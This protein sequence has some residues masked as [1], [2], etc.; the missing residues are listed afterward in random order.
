VKAQLTV[1][2]QLPREATPDHLDILIL[3]AAEARTAGVAPAIDTLMA[4]QSAM[5]AAAPRAEVQPRLFLWQQPLA[6]VAVALLVVGIGVSTVSIVRGPGQEQVAEA[7]AVED[8][9]AEAARPE[10]PEEAV[11]GTEPE[12]VELAEVSKDEVA[13]RESE[14]KPP[15]ARQAQ[16]AR[17][18]SQKK[19]ERR[20]AGRDAPAPAAPEQEPQRVAAAETDQAADT[21]AEQ[22]D[23]AK[24]PAMKTGDSKDALSF[25]KANGQQGATSEAE[26]Q[27]ISTILMFEKRLKDKVN[28]KPTPQ[29]AL[30]AGLCYQRL[31]KRNQAQHWLKRAAEYPSTSARAKEALDQLK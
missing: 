21:S 20:A 10:D 4:E 5:D 9:T 18:R 3:Q 2:S 28:Y 16:A 30:D 31:G 25:G 17:A 12:R 11:G 19:K 27:C 24:L 8:Q 6:M 1:A 13:A 7:P 22:Y 29:Q 26:R 14:A 23:A 15:A